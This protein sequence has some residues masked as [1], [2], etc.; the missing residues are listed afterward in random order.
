MQ[1]PSKRSKLRPGM[2][3]KKWRSCWEWNTKS[4]GN[5]SFSGENLVKKV[6]KKSGMEALGLELKSSA[7]QSSILTTRLWSLL[8]L[9]ALPQSLIYS[10]P[11]EP[12]LNYLCFFLSQLGSRTS[13]VW[14]TRQWA[15]ELTVP[16]SSP[17]PGSN[18]FFLSLPQFT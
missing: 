10:S 11:S 9:V 1:K 5:S 7:P 14:W 18:F 17:W 15:W 3:K 13:T 8:L 16:C 4:A 12:H 2:K 6:E